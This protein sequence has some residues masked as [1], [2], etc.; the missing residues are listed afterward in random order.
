MEKE[1]AVDK[2]TEKLPLSVEL[3]KGRPDLADVIANSIVHADTR[4]RIAVGV[5]GP[6]DLVDRTRDVVRRDVYDNGPSITLY[7]EVRLY[8]L[9]FLMNETVIDIDYRNS[10]GN[11]IDDNENR[12]F[13]CFHK[14][15]FRL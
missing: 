8:I 15:T 9:S 7:S 10:D 11:D 2:T 5:C 14:Y 4:D 1:A 12:T 3:H 6:S 13:R